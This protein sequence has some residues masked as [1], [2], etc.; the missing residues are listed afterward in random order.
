MTQT[1]KLIEERIK[2]LQFLSEFHERQ[3]KNSSSELAAL[4]EDYECLLALRDN[5]KII[6]VGRLENFI[7]NR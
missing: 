5:E 4:K 2:K 1:L 6:E 3:F 7:K